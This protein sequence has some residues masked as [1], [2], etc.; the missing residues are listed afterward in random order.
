[1]IKTTRTDENVEYIAKER[2]K[3]WLAV[4]RTAFTSVGER[5]FRCSRRSVAIGCRQI[6]QVRV[7][8][9]VRTANRLV[10]LITNAVVVLAFAFVSQS[11]WLRSGFSAFVCRIEEAFV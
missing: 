9:A 5:D 4:A 6:A 7:S 11:D 1:M 3:Y 10:E 8:L 2:P